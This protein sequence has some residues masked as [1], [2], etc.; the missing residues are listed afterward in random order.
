MRAYPGQTLKPT[1]SKTNLEQGEQLSSSLLPDVF[2]DPVDTPL[3]LFYS[4]C[5]IM[6][7]NLVRRMALFQSNSN[8]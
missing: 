2:L 3:C 1:N 4:S 5:L 7:H 6:S 8:S